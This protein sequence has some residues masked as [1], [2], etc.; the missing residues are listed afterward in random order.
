M[1]IDEP[2]HQFNFMTRANI[3]KVLIVFVCVAI[4]VMFCAKS[5]T[6]SASKTFSALI[7]ENG[8]LIIPEQS[9][10]RKVVTV[11]AVKKQR[12]IRP[13]I[14]PATVQIDPARLLNVLT[15]VLGQIT[16]IDKVLGEN[17]NE[18]DALFSI[19]SPDF[20]QAVSDVEKANAVLILSRQTY[21]RQ[22]QLMASKI[23]SIHDI[24]QAKS[25]YEQA[26]SEYIRAKARL[27]ELHANTTSSHGQSVLT[28]KSPI[29]GY[30]IDMKAA[31]REYWTDVTT[32][33]MVIADLSHVYLNASLQEKD[34]G[35]AYIG[36]PIEFTFPMHK[37]KVIHS[38]INYISPVLNPETRT[39]DVGVLYDNR[40]GLL[41]PNT[42]ANAILMARP[43]NRILLPLTA[44]IQR[45]FDSIVFV[46]VSPWVFEPRVVQV[47]PQ[48]KDNIEIISGLTTGERVA[49]TGG[50]IL[51]D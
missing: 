15:P 14:A 27:K 49:S 50:I 24:Q 23:S 29:T 3:V 45:G 9:P 6:P 19:H 38:Q 43:K 40:D 30:V 28:I 31:T 8:R 11:D 46:E 26:E 5:L 48:I 36:Q 34:I 20:S 1:F 33:V 12:V 41:R 13:F 42:F 18:G 4:L 2:D 44:V 7:H 35:V 22:K 21:E 47:G 32:P 10:L 39:I 16:Q 37:K 17:V 25:E 51:N